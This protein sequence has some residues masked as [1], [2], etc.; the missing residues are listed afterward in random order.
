MPSRLIFSCAAVIFETLYAVRG[1]RLSHLALWQVV[2]KVGWAALLLWVQTNL[3]LRLEWTWG[4]F[5]GWIPVGVS[6]RRPT[7]SE[8][9]S[10]RADASFLWRDRIIVSL[11]T[12]QVRGPGIK[13]D[14]VSSYL[15]LLPLLQLFVG[16]CLL[17][18]FLPSL[19]LIAASPPL[20]TGES[21]YT[22]RTTPDTSLFVR[23]VVSLVD[24]FSTA[25]W[26]S[27]IILQCLLNVKRQTFAGQLKTNAH[28]LLLLAVLETAPAVLQGFLGRA[29]LMEPF[30]VWDGAAL[31]LAGWRA[32]QAWTYPV[33][34]QE[35]SED[36]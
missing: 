26:Y 13:A 36:D 17:E 31:A 32:W 19:H 15:P 12:V 4:V 35:E 18:R 9:A 33:V 8:R 28:V 22:F 27:V 30:T 3:A 20:P 25:L 14:T 10:A 11:S 1:Y 6:R 2:L 7:H 34:A 29:E 5:R 23:T 21:A 16:I 24:P